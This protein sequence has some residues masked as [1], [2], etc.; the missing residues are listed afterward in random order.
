MTERRR[1]AARQAMMKTRM[2]KAVGCAGLLLY[3]AGYVG[4]VATLGAALTPRLPAWGLLAFFAIAGV[5]WIIPL[6]PL[7]AWMNRDR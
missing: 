2:R 1:T 5:V 3:L 4:I 7:F 6:K